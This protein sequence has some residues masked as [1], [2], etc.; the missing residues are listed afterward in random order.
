M[1]SCCSLYL[2]VLI[3]GTNAYEE[4]TCMMDLPNAVG[5]ASL[6]T[7][8]QIAALARLLPVAQKDGSLPDLTQATELEGQEGSTSTR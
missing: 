4:S 3:K 2:V 7:Q 1:Q 5:G 8:V 6:G